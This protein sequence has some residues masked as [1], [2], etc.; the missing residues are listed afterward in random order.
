MKS[1]LH[2]PDDVSVVGFDD[3][4]NAKYLEP[5]LTTVRHSL[6]DTSE[7]I[8]EKLKEQMEKRRCAPYSYTCYPGK[9]IVRES[10]RRIPV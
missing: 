10:V 7:E 3:I 5:P 2:I 6:L 9:L 4:P 8:F 1:G